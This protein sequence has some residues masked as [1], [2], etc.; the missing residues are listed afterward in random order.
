M[1]LKDAEVGD[2]V[3]FRYKQPVSGPSKRFLAKVV[4]VRNLTPEEVANIS[5]QSKYRRGDSEFHR[6][7]TLVTCDLPGGKVR[8]FYAE[9]SERCAKPFMGHASFMIQDA[10]ARS[11]G[12]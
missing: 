12:W 5:S 8:N 7:L 3:N 4:A 6:T 2:V 11:I 1:E 9:R 10:I